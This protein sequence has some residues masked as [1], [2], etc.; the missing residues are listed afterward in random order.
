[1]SAK[2]II[3]F[4]HL[5]ATRTHILDTLKTKNKTEVMGAAQEL[6]FAFSES[7]FDSF[8]WGAEA[9]LAIK[10]NEKFD[11]HFPLW[12]MMWGKYYLEYLAIDLM[13]SIE[14]AGLSND[15]TEGI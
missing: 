5:L 10:R 1:M 12:Q 9:Q 2:N 3:H 7:E 15:L 11:A 6:G 4:L 13:P 8:I 14:E